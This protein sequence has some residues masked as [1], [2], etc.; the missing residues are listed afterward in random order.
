MTRVHPSL[1]AYFK[2]ARLLIIVSPEF[3]PDMLSPVITLGKLVDTIGILHHSINRLT[4]QLPMQNILFPDMVS[5]KMPI[6]R[7][8]NTL[9]I[10]ILH[11]ILIHIRQINLTKTLSAH[12]RKPDHMLERPIR[13]TVRDFIQNFTVLRIQRR[14]KFFIAHPDRP[15]EPVIPDDMRVLLLAGPQLLRED[16]REQALELAVGQLPHEAGEVVGVVVHEVPVLRADLLHL[17]RGRGLEERDLRVGF[18]LR[19]QFRLVRLPP[20]LVHGGRW[21]HWTGRDHCWGEG[22][23]MGDIPSGE[24]WSG[25]GAREWSG[26]RK[27]FC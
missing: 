3:I 7:I 26:E 8:L 17:L 11:K 10:R 23:A 1:L 24:S 19:V 20:E 16:L 5:P 15:Q 18:V 12:T 4:H 22:R 21:D 6:H 9:N 13:A 27:H 25:E 2:S 14:R